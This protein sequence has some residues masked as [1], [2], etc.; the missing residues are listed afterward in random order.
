MFAALN[1]ESASVADASPTHERAKPRRQMAMATYA[2][3]EH[4]GFP[5]TLFEGFT[6]FVLVGA[7]SAVLLLMFRRRVAKKACWTPEAPL[8][9]A[10]L[11][12]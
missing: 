4:K 12:R 8:P 3:A 6:A 5:M 2:H 11:I 9:S 1:A 7:W 10:W